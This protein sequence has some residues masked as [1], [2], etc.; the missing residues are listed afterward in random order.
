MDIIFQTISISSDLGDNK[1]DLLYKI[2]LVKKQKFQK[3]LLVIRNLKTVYFRSIIVSE[4]YKFWKI[5]SGKKYL[6]EN[7]N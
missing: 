6:N 1:I 4:E 7:I 5:I 3:F 2:N